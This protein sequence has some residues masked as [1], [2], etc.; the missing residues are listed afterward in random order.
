MLRSAPSLLLRNHPGLHSRFAILS[1]HLGAD[2]ARRVL[3]YYSQVRP[4]SHSAPLQRT[5]PLQASA[6]SARQHRACL[7][8]DACST[9][10]HASAACIRQAAQGLPARVLHPA[11]RMR[12]MHV[13]V[14]TFSEALLARKLAALTGECGFHASVIAGNPGLL[15][16]S[17]DRRV[18]PRMRRMHAAA[19]A[20]SGGGAPQPKKQAV[21]D[22]RELNGR[23]P[24][25][26]VKAMF[27]SER[28]FEAFLERLAERGHWGAA[29]SA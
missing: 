24:T 9:L 6:G 22:G 18:L 21:V 20:A 3:I 13:Q 16:F 5:R 25:S 7:R 4:C 1:E 14:L 28:D 29:R 8:V 11:T 2:A 12:R 17:L 10:R 26:G 27:L 19:R 23:E 15:G